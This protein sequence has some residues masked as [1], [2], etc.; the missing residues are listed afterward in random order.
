MMAVLGE[1]ALIIKKIMHVARVFQL[2][3]V[4]LQRFMASFHFYASEMLRQDAT[5]LD[6]NKNK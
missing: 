3:I 1:V 6:K 2:F 5:L 4:T